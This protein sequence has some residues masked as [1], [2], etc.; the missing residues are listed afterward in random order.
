MTLNFCALFHSLPTS[1]YSLS[2][3][4]AWSVL[5]VQDVGC[6]QGPGCQAEVTLGGQECQSNA[7]N[8]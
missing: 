5:H 1:D 7:E 8:Y 3:A 2:V 4:A 6:G